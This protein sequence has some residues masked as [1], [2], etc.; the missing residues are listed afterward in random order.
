MFKCPVCGSNSH[1]RTSEY[2]SET[3]KRSYY[4]CVNVDCMCAYTTLEFYE[5][6]LTKRITANDENFNQTENEVN[7]YGKA[8]YQK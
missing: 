3:V 7:K 8:I 5:K 2:L 4:N 1:T 6:K